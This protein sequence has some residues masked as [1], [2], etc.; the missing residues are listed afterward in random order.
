MDKVA[1]KNAADEKQVKAAKDKELR[2]RELEMQDMANVLATPSGRRLVWRLLKHCRVFETI[3]H[4]SALIHYNAGMQDV[5]H[6]ILA[7]INDA[8]P[9]SLLRMIKENK[10]D[11]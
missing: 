4:N 2:G 7:E 1:V 8:D 9:D 3:W 11:Q 6:F 5:G 10:G